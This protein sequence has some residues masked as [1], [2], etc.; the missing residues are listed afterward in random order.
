MIL[1]EDSWTADGQADDIIAYSPDH[2]ILTPDQLYA[3]DSQLFFEHTY[4]CNTEIVQYHLFKLHR[5]NLVPNT[6]DPRFA[7]WY[8]RDIE[9]TTVAEFGKYRGTPK[10]IKPFDNNKAFDGRVITDIREFE[11]YGVPI[12]SSETK[13]YCCDPVVFLSEVRLLIGNGKLYGH[14]HICK[15]K[16]PNYLNDIKIADIIAA[17]NGEYLCIDIGYTPGKWIIIEVNPPWSLDDHEI[18][19]ADYMAFCIDACAYIRKC[20]LN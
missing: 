11:D 16:I 18:P 2:Q 3:F 7:K 20:V 17:T 12:P 4:F 8:N 19:F 5:S 6:Y 14:G 13:I 15:N 1:I 9:T 10:F